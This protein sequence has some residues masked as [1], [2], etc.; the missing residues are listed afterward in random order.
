MA[1]PSSW[2]GMLNVWQYLF[3]PVG[4]IGSYQSE[5]MLNGLFFRQIFLYTLLTTVERY[6]ARASPYVPIVGVSHLTRSVHY[7][8]HDAYFKPFQVG[9]S[10]TNL[11]DGVA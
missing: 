11:L 5:Q 9:S 4:S 3:F 6:V 10:L 8:T 1:L 2:H 7:A